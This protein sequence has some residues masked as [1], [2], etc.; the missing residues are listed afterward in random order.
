MSRFYTSIFESLPASSDGVVRHGIVV[1]IHFDLSHDPRDILGY[2]SVD[3]G[4]PRV[5]AFDAPGD[6]AAHV[7][8]RRIVG[9]FAEQRP[10]GVAL[11]R[12]LVHSYIRGH[13]RKMFK[14][15]KLYLY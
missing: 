14:N 15:L 1:V 9:V 4:E 8:A 2:V 10:A 11:E 6:D 13:C 12:E 3:A 7:P 5:G